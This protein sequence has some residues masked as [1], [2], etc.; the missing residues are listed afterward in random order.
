MK[1]PCTTMPPGN[2]LN[3]SKLIQIIG[4][5]V[6][7]NSTHHSARVLLPRVGLVTEHAVKP[8]VGPLQGA[9]VE[10]GADVIREQIAA[11]QDEQPEVDDV[12]GAA[13][14][15]AEIMWVDCHNLPPHASCC[16]E[17]PHV[18]EH[19]LT[20]L[21]PHHVSEHNLTKIQRGK[22]SGTYTLPSLLHTP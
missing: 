14:S 22:G 13:L 18:V 4:A 12:A 20:V 8:K 1:P 2:C 9:Q 3:A 19:P 5:S 16:V 11:A 15:A 6:R 7:G 17:L 21:T 10:D